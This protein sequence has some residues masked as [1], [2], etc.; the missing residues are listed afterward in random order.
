MCTRLKFKL[1]VYILAFNACDYFLEAAVFSGAF[2][3]HLYPPTFLLRKLVVHAKQV[4]REN[5]RLVA[6]CAGSYL[7]KY[8]GLV[9][10]VLGY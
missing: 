2:I 9:V 4:T 10:G 6:A 7:E 5:G 1:A 3:H 8:I